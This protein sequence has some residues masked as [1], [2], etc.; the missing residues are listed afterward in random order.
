MNNINYH[1]SFGKPRIQ[2]ENNS[3]YSS[4]VVS[5]GKET[6]INDINNNKNKISHINVNVANNNN[7]ILKDTNIHLEPP[8]KLISVNTKSTEQLLHKHNAYIK[9]SSHDH[10]HIVSP[11]TTNPN[12]NINLNINNEIQLIP[13]TEP[14]NNENYFKIQ[15]TTNIQIPWEYINSIYHNLLTEEQNGIIPKPEYNYMSNQKE[16]NQQMRSILIDWLIEVHHKFGFTD[17]TLYMTVFIIDRFLTIEQIT[18]STLQL[19]GITALMIACKHEEI[20]LPKV[21]DFIYI[22]DNAYTR[23][24]VFAMENKVLNRL[25]FSL[26]YPSPI[27]FFELLANGFNFNNKQLMMGKYLMESFLIDLKN[28]KYKGSVIACATAYVVMKFFKLSNYQESYNRKYY[29]LNKDCESNG[30]NVV[31]ECAKDICLFVDNIHKTNFKSTQKKFSKSKYEKV[32]LLI[33]GK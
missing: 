20:D 11:Q 17:E 8:L 6:D 24:E 19:L 29:C 2:K 10:H 7:E 28:I 15:S 3:T 16:I 14:F 18:R 21:D 4:L 26:L 9:Q 22:T 12:T 30:D 5:H 1:H 32:A 13:N 33:L 31:K 23:D 27:K 25:N